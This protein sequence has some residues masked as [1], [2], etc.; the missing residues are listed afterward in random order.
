LWVCFITLLSTSW[1]LCIVCVV[2][3]LVTSRS[4]CC[5]FFLAVC[6]SF[7]WFCILYVQNHKAYIL[8]FLVLFKLM[9]VKFVHISW[10]F[11]IHIYLQ[12][13]VVRIQHSLS[14]WPLMGTRWVSRLKQSEYVAMKILIEVF[15]WTYVLTF[16]G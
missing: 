9:F 1:V 7:V 10:I 3:L 15:W 6:V 2:C 4:S 12:Y 13:S 5:C 11:S 14:I 16:I 8:L